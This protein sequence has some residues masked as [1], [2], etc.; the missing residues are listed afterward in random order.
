[1]SRASRGCN[2]ECCDNVPLATDTKVS[3]AHDNARRRTRRNGKCSQF[4][5]VVIGVGFASTRV[6]IRISHG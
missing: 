6:S 1:M 5:G 3:A 4:T 2:R